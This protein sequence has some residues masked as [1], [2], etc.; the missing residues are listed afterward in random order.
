MYIFREEEGGNVKFDVKFRNLQSMT[1][2]LLAD[3]KTYFWGKVTWKS[4]TCKIFLNSLKKS[5]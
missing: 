1:P 5:L 3:E 4:V 2:K